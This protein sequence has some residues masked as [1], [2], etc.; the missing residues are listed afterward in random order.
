MWHFGPMRVSEPADGEARLHSINEL[1]CN[2]SQG[3]QGFLLGVLGE[4]EVT[5]LAS[6]PRSR[7]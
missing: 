6:D 2:T 7:S 4:S 5:F 3:S 1:D